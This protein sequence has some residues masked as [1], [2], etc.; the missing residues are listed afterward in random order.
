[1]NYQRAPPNSSPVTA[2][3]NLSIW[4]LIS[5]LSPNQWL[6]SFGVQSNAS[7]LLDLDPPIAST[8]TA[9]FCLLCFS[10]LPYSA[11]FSSLFSALFPLSASVSIAAA[12]APSFVFLSFILLMAWLLTL[13]ERLRVK[14]A[15]IS[16]LLYRVLDCFSLQSSFAMFGE[17]VWSNGKVEDKFSSK[18]ILL[19]GNKNAY[20]LLILIG[21]GG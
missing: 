20:F 9:I 5:L 4:A 18:G 19:T 13:N 21:L 10:L 2:P 17:A 3:F 7:S 1:M 16:G 15:E 8:L 12:T 14:L 6:S 11:C